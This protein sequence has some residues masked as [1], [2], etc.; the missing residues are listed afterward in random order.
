M[1]ADEN[2]ALVNAGGIF[3]ALMTVFFAGL[4][5]AGVIGWSWV[6]VV[7]PLWL[8]LAL[9]IIL[10]IGIFIV[11]VLVDTISDMLR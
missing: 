4:K 9:T 8:P 10:G 7:S 3:I 5:L 1:N 2:K 11:Y 6:W